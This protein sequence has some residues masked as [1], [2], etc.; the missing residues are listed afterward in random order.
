MFC[1]LSQSHAVSQTAKRLIIDHIPGCQG[2]SEGVP[3]AKLNHRGGVLY[4]TPLICA[5]VNIIHS[6]DCASCR[7]KPQS[8][9]SHHDLPTIHHPVPLYRQLVSQPDGRGLVSQP[10]QAATCS[11]FT[12]HLPLPHSCSPCL[13]VLRTTGL[14][15]CTQ[16]CCFHTAREF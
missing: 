14:A 16:V 6:H 3:C 1:P 11:P 4:D 8:A 15:S 7:S 13:L 10:H 9:L 5:S 12:L 2:V